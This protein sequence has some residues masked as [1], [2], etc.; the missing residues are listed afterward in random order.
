MGQ[1]AEFTRPEKACSRD[2]GSEQD[3]TPSSSEEQSKQTEGTAGEGARPGAVQARQ[4][5]RWLGRGRGAYGRQPVLWPVPTPASS[6]LH[7]GPSP[8]TAATLTSRWGVD[9]PPCPPHG[10]QRGAHSVGLSEIRG[11]SHT[12]ASIH[13]RL[14][15]ESRRAGK[16]KGGRESRPSRHGGA[17]GQRWAAPGGQ[18]SR[19]WAEAWGGVSA[20]CVGEGRGGCDGSEEQQL[21]KPSEYCCPRAPSNTENVVGTTGAVLPLEIHCELRKLKCSCCHIKRVKTK[22]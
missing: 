2:P 22:R 21:L 12:Q 10:W 15:G 20:S 1:G 13:V 8:G 11:K 14:R 7:R 18:G 6:A 16:E 5:G 3:L 17:R 4:G 9:A 19:E